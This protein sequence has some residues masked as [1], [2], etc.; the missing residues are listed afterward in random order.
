MKDN[1]R[2]TD[3]S[4]SHLIHNLYGDKDYR[5]IHTTHNFTDA[6]K[7]FL[8]ITKSIKFAIEETITIADNYHKQELLN[9]ITE[10]ERLI[11]S[12]KSFDSLDQQMVS[13]Q[14]ELIF[15]LI[16]LMPHRWQQQKVINKRSSWKLDDYRQIQYM[17]NANH[18]KNIIFG[19]VQ[20]KC[21]GKYGS[22]GDFLYNI[23]YKQCHRDPDELILWFKKN[24]ADIYSELF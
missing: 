16:G 24:H 10:S 21:K 6:K 1:Y 17:Q 3:M 22:W 18:K 12:S 14:S 20:S 9:T 19:A 11:K 23:Y 7:Y 13:F 2:K 8:K 15:L 5:L 4:F